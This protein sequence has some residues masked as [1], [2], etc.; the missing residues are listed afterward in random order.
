LAV[1][2]LCLRLAAVWFFR[3]GG[4]VF[5][6]D[7]DVQFYR[8]IGE[9]SIA[10]YY[11]YL[12]YWMEY[13]PIFAWAIVGVYRLSLLLPAWP[14]NLLWFQIILS[15]ILAVFDLGNLIVIYRLA[16][17]AYGRSIALR[18]AWIYALLFFPLYAVLS[19]FDTVALFFLLLS[20][21]LAL[22]GRAAGAGLAAALGL[23]VKV[24]PVIAVPVGFLSFHRLSG[25][26]Q[27]ASAFVLTAVAIAVPF[28][29][30]NP[31][32]SVASLRVI[33]GR[34]SW[35]TIWAFFEGYYSIGIVPL[36]SSR[37][38][39]RLADW[40]PH[41]ASLP[42]PAI[43]GTFF[44][45][46]FLLFTRRLAWHKPAVNLTAVALT[47]N[48]FLVFSKGF[49]PQFMVYPL[50]LLIL[51]LPNAWG[52]LYAL[53]LTANDLLEYP[54]ALGFFGDDHRMSWLVIVV[55]TALL[56]WLSIEYA[57]LL[58]A[59]PRGVWSRVRPYLG[60]TIAGAAALGL[61]V[62]AGLGIGHYFTPTR[63]DDA[64]PLA[65]YVRTFAGPAD[66]AIATSRD[67]FY[68]LR[69]RLAIGDWVLG[70]GDDGQW[71][72]SLVDR[73]AT[74][75]SGKSR[76]WVIVD[77]AGPTGGDVPK[78]IQA[79]DA[80][81]TRA[82]DTWFGRYHLL[83]YLPENPPTAS[84]SVPSHADFGGI[85]SFEGY[86]LSSRAIKP[87]AG[88]T[89]A[90][91]FKA[92]AGV[93]KDY[94]AFVHLLSAQGHIVAQRDRPLSHRGQPS[95]KWNLGE[96]DREGYDLLV[97]VGTSC[98]QY[99]LEI[100]LYD[101]SSGQRLRIKS[102]PETGADTVLLPAVRVC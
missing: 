97:P 45:L 7:H 42:W 10:G 38:D 5:Q 86:D 79:M 41:V 28:Y 83:G 80:W 22:R 92:E 96:S 34:S 61:I 49:S 89:L 58:F 95:T 67:A 99:D 102:G 71:P 69:P 78:A 17:L 19:W 44:L 87:G 55:R 84:P 2:F 73:V 24:V 65:S 15:T 100:G 60:S 20:V 21:W 64:V 68:E 90:L 16:T 101:P 3:S 66:G 13:P 14:N 32:M 31:T 40:S 48:L 63:P 6:G 4:N 8:S 59:K 26:L 74:L 98:G 93:P 77:Q 27:Y 53:L 85:L 52:V 11:P 47:L 46:C 18:V 37:F 76:I 91:Y 33:I 29:V 62:V 23:M 81:G 82:T 25:R 57:G 70:Q 30:A 75:Q 94:K 54:F 36:L 56:L 35:E 88:L 51:V 72:T 39:P 12:S 9:L 1:L 50:A 43:T